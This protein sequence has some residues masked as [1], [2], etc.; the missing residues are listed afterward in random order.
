MVQD[1]NLTIKKRFEEEG[2]DFGFPSRILHL[3]QD[4]QSRTLVT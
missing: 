3:R 4:S 2:I 1:L